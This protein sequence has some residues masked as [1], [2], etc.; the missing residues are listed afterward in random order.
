MS[1]KMTQAKYESTLNRLVA[2]ENHTNDIL[3][4]ISNLASL[5]Q[6]KELLVVLQASLSDIE[7]RII[8]LENRVT[9]IEEE[10]LK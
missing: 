5:Q 9:A 3:V 7:D 8:A 4:A 1:F 2:L 10:P 6:V